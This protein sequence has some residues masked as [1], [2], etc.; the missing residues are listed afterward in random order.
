MTAI[1]KVPKHIIEMLTSEQQSRFN[2]FVEKW[3]AIGV[4]TAPA[5]RPRAEAGI[6][7]AYEIA[8]LTPPKSIVWCDSPL[9]QRLTRAIV[10]GLSGDSEA[11]VG[12]S[13]RD[14]V[15]ASVRDSV[16]DSVWDSV[17]DSVFG[18]HD[19]HWLAFY[20][21]FREACGLSRETQR[22]C[23][24]LEVA[25]SANWWLPHKHIC[26][27]SER[28]HVLHGDDDG[29]LDCNDGPA[30]A[31][32]D[33]WSIWSIRGVRVN[34][35]IVLHPD[36][37]SISEIDSEENEEVRR[38]RIERFGVMR[39]LEESGAT[40][41]DSRRNDIENTYEILADTKHG[42]RLVTHCPSTGRRYFLAIPD[43]VENCEQAQRCLWGNITCNI[44]GRT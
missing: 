12:A 29:R 25:Q 16:G 17:G 22:L 6:R 19:A 1:T 10:F 33:G 31:Y 41:I 23:G 43:R 8:G 35:Q 27:V 26:W 9:S 30:L 40:V 14:S 39:Y 4:S 11:S 7:K 34:E 20:D 32:P 24:L 42:Q 44:I 18:Q 38:I 15:W 3:T 37:Q 36:T 13:V 2:E 21:Y 5:D 28:H